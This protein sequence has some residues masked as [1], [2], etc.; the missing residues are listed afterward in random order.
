MVNLL[1]QVIR[2]VAIR[3]LLEHK[4]WEASRTE[5]VMIP[6]KKIQEFQTNEITPASSKIQP[7]IRDQRRR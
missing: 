6:L 4:N 7:K 3:V 1:L 2:F 5:T